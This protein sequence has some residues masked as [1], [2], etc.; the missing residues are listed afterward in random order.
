M[1]SNLFLYAYYNY[2]KQW[3][4][5]TEWDAT[6]CI[7]K[8]I[9]FMPSFYAMVKG[10]YKYTDMFESYFWTRFY[11]FACSSIFVNFH[12]STRLKSC[13]FFICIID[14]FVH[15]GLKQISILYRWQ[16]CSNYRIEKFS[17][18][19][20]FLNFIDMFCLQHIK[21]IQWQH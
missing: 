18:R 17:R 11:K 19:C 4:I 5:I 9:M 2:L 21:N 15:W 10:K 6:S 20:E 8:P 12:T 3:R 16:L 14:Y 1:F 13:L 7:I